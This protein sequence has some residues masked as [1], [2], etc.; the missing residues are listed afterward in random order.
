MEEQN[1]N[2][3]AGQAPAGQTQTHQA[4]AGPTPAGPPPSA[5]QAPVGHTSTGQAPV[6]TQAPAGQ[7]PGN[8]PSDFDPER[9][10]ATIRKLRGFEKEAKQLKAQLRALQQ[11]LG[12][13]AEDDTVDLAEIQARIEALAEEK[14]TLELKSAVVAMA[15]NTFLHPEDAWHLID[16]SKL[17]M[18]D[19]GTIDGLAEELKRLVDEHRLPL[20]TGAVS[21]VNPASG[22]PDRRE[23][24]RRDY[25]G[26]GKGARSPM[27]TGGGLLIHP[28]SLPTETGGKGE[29]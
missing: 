21:P 9:A 11:S 13:Q 27:W 3:P 6:S 4:P 2:V 10:M 1:T 5:G 12:L 16:V 26:H 24:Y 15:A 29:K 20:R 18:K 7:A 19:D 25:F 14:N 28:T 8:P 22:T 17:H 23:Q